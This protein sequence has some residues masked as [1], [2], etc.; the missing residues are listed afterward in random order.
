MTDSNSNSTTSPNLHLNA[1]RVSMLVPNTELDE[2][3]A[4]LPPGNGHFH[5]ATDSLP[6]ASAEARASAPPAGYGETWVTVCS[7]VDK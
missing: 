3:L 2:L 6:A 5:V 1:P 4:S 7:G